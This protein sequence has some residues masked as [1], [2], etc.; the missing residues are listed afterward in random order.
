[1]PV[2]L[3]SLLASLS[4][5]LSLSL[6][7]CLAFPY[8]ACCHQYTVR[9]CLL[10]YTL[11]PPPDIQLTIVIGRFRVSWMCFSTMRHS[12]SP[13][14]LNK[15]YAMF[16]ISSLSLPLCNYVHRWM[17]GLHV[18]HL[19]MLMQILD[20]V[21]TPDNLKTI[22]NT[23]LII[24][25]V[26]WRFLSHI[27]LYSC[28]PALHAFLYVLFLM[29]GFLPL[30]LSISLCMYVCM[31]VCVCQ[32]VGGVVRESVDN[33]VTSGTI[34]KF[35]LQT[36]RTEVNNNKQQ[37]TIQSSLSLTIITRNAWH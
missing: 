34:I 26:L 15:R 4:L 1:M 9:I 20:F 30:P 3:T 28:V 31:Y 27:F 23:P 7:V 32:V 14:L 29:C 2:V 13:S 21:N 6:C 24:T 22:F 12:F 37:Q 35:F 8:V 5:S 18:A 33:N 16:M 10:T 11:Q 36:V 19:T 25:K 17:S